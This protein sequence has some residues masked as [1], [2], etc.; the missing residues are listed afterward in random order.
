M[1]SR[2]KGDEYAAEVLRTIKNIRVEHKACTAAEVSR[3]MRETH[4][5]VVRQLA[6]LRE[7]GLVEWTEMP[8]SLSV[9]GTGGKYIL[10]VEAG[11]TPLADAKRAKLAA[12]APPDPPG[13]APTE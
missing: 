6:V 1:G 9:T 13:E 7:S 12:E 10:A 5:L 2:L 4:T 8:G 3:L 11:Q